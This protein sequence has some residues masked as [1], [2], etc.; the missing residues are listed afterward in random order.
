MAANGTSIVLLRTCLSKRTCL[1]KLQCLNFLNHPEIKRF[2]THTSCYVSL[3]QHTKT[4]SRSVC[5]SKGASISNLVLRKKWNLQPLYFQLG[6][7]S[8]CLS[9]SAVYHQEE[10]PNSSSQGIEALPGYIPEPPQVPVLNADVENV[11]E[12]KGS[13][14]LNAG[15]GGWSPVGIIQHCLDYLHVSLNIPWW[16]SIVISTLVV[17]ILMFPVAIKAQQNATKMNNHL[18]KM[19]ML[20]LKI[21]EARKSGNSVE[22]AKYS[23][24]LMIFM[25]E[26]KINPLKNMIVPLVQAPVFISFFMALRKMANLPLESMKTGGTLWFTDLT[27]PDPMYGLPIITCVTL[28]III[29]VGAEGGLR[30]DSLH[31]MRYFLRAMPLVVLP[32]SINFPAAVLCYWT[33][34]NLISLGQVGLLRTGPVRDFFKIPKLVRHDPASLPMKKKGFVKGLKESMKTSREIRHMEDRRQLDEIQF[35]K[36]GTGPIKKTYPFDPTNQ[37]PGSGVTQ[38]AKKR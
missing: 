10:V 3:L 20:Q 34:S 26:N 1:L 36:A 29:E 7:Q 13:E 8:T 38:T 31:L 25:K 4:H 37:R 18:P 14:L 6:G 35:R 28:S 30:S 27:V 33:T 2:N 21:S 12:E 23:N 5:I 16:L 19:Q 11:L 15:L 32:F 17:R 9:T 24:E 22:A